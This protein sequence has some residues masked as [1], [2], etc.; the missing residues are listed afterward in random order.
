[1]NKDSCIDEHFLKQFA[2]S[3]SADRP[4]EI[5]EKNIARITILHE[6]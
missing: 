3:R 1:M 2:A 4:I 6:K 5:S